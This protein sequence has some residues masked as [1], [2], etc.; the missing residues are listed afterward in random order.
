MKTV[1]QSL[2]LLVLMNETA[3]GFSSSPF[4]RRQNALGC[5][6][7]SSLKSESSANGR[8]VVVE[9]FLGYFRESVLSEDFQSLVLQGPSKKALR[10]VGNDDCTRG[11]IRQASARMIRLKKGVNLQMLV[12]YHLATDIAKNW[13][14]SDVEK[15]VELLRFILLGQ[16]GSN[17][18]DDAWNELSSEWSSKLVNPASRGRKVGIQTLTLQT[19]SVEY[20]INFGQKKPKIRKAKHKII[21]ET[22]PSTHD[23]DKNVP[24]GGKESFLQALGV[25]NAEGKPRPGKAGKLRQIQVFCRVV[26]Q[27]IEAL[28]PVDFDE[29]EILDMGCGRGYLTFSLHHH[30]SSLN[31]WPAIKTTGI[32]VR[33]KLVGE[34]NAIAKSQEGFENLN[35][36]TGVIENY[37][38]AGKSSSTNSLRVLI[39]LHACDT[40][41]DD[42]LWAAIQHDAHVIVVA[43]CCHRQIR[44]QLDAHYSKVRNGGH[45]MAEIW[46]FAIYRERT[47][48]TVTDTLRSL[49]LEYAGYTTNNF[50]FVSPEHTSKNLMI[51]AVKKK[52]QRGSCD[53]EE[54]IRTV[55][56]F[57]GIHSMKLADWV[58]FDLGAKKPILNRNSMPNNV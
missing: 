23:R 54:K 33:P 47:A 37:L 12:K 14:K 22:T 4:P 58:D 26:Q 42:A 29:I 30:L 19:R 10:D 32:D 53:L 38:D 24:L 56:E 9:E 36:E 20:S 35:F 2:F 49:L 18:D 51:T 57:H 13:P 25:T 6:L 31:D 50:E 11:L 46:R 5:V 21:E 44:G 55:A 52:S 27:H 39:A 45:P 7:L 43:P 1:V 16:D 40:A 28:Q 17:H 48:E 15:V 34:I 3:D 8:T 41:T